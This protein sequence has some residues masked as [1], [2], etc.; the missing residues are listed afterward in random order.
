ML[1]LAEIEPAKRRQVP[2][3]LRFFQQIE[4]PVELPLEFE[5]ASLHVEYRLGRNGEPV[6]QAFNWLAEGETETPVL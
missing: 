2:F 3:S 6:R 4:I 1:P 5:P